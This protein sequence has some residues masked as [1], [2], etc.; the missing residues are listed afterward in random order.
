MYAST[1]LHDMCPT[2][3]NILDAALA[4]LAREG[5]GGA[6]TRKI[7]EEAGINEV[8]LF[9]KFKS[10]EK[11]IKDAKALSMKRA[12]ENMDRTFRLLEGQDF[13][14]SII[15][16]GTHVS[17]S[18]NKKT[19][20]IIT[21]I[22]DLQKLPACERTAPKY[23]TAMLD[24][25]T[26]YFQEQ[27]EKGNMRGVDAKTAALSFFS[28]IFYMNFIGKLNG[29]DPAN[30]GDRTMEEFMDIFMNGVLVPEK[31]TV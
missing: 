18:V 28:Y 12:L 21:A 17:E 10:K 14:T 3:E 16:L 4:V 2:D 19:N 5:Y 30:N 24:H 1:Y 6:T 25:L 29:Q 15:T 22:A 23:S 9:R 7:A 26:K 27:I 8:T 13:N 31:K 20:M 11:L